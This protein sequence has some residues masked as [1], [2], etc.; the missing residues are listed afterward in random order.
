MDPKVILA[1]PLVIL[2]AG[3]SITPPITGSLCTAGP[4]ILDRGAATRLSR[5]EKEQIVTLNESGAKICGW[6]APTK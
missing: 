6:K 1:L 5:D 3:C 2:L 4:V